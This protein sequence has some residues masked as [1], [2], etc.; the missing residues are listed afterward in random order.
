MQLTESPN[1]FEKETNDGLVKR[2]NLNVG[3]KPNVF[4]AHIKI[5]I[6]L[7]NFLDVVVR[8]SQNVCFI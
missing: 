7:N 1:W 5:Q 2:F 4:S 3:K 6:K 8:G